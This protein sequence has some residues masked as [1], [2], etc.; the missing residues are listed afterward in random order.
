[1]LFVGIGG[2][3][4]RVLRQLRRRFHDR[5]GTNEKIPAIEFLLL[6]TDIQS[7]NSAAREAG[8]LEL[9]ASEMVP[10]PLRPAEAYRS[11]VGNTLGSISRRWLF[12]IPYSLQTEGLRPL[13]AWPWSTIPN[14]FWSECG[15]RC[16]RH[17]R[18]QHR[19]D[20]KAHGTEIRRPCPPRLRRGLDLR[21]H[22]KRHGL[23]RGLRDPLG[24][25]RGEPVGRACLWRFDA[26]L[27]ARRRRS[28]QSDRK[29]L[30]CAERDVEFFCVENAIQAIAG[31]K[32]PPSTATTER[33]PIAI[34]CTWAIG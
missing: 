9:R 28:R 17:R 20:G 18:D 21:W 12:N 16:P 15:N 31:A 19:G 32:C 26:W 7:L 29:L 10:M 2:L 1:M 6:D 30:C 8:G 24:I 22:R 27:A 13:D 33:L 23:G 11:M 3:A 4:M 34:C 25:G 14:D 5:Q